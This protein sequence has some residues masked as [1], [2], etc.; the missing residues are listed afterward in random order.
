MKKDDF[1]EEVITYT[2]EE[3]KKAVNKE[4]EKNDRFN[5]NLCYGTLQPP[6]LER[7]LLVSGLK[8]GQTID[9]KESAYEYTIL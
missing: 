5:L 1:Y 7:V 2:Y 3:L 8:E 4:N 6:F 9:I